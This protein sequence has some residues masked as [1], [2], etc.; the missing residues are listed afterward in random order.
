MYL[1]GAAVRN[2]VNL[3]HNDLEQGCLCIPNEPVCMLASEQADN[4]A[5]YTV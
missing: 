5:L 2:G 4:L 3:V 1:H